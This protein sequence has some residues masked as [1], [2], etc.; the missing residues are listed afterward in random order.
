MLE[1]EVYTYVPLGATNLPPCY[2]AVRR[3]AEAN[4]FQIR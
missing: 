2:F 3:T 4:A 1:R